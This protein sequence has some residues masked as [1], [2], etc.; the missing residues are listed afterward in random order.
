MI[1]VSFIN[2]G[3][4]PVSRISLNMLMRLHLAVKGRFLIIEYVMLSLPGEVSF[5]FKLRL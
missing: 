3:I 4:L 1:I 2:V 5:L